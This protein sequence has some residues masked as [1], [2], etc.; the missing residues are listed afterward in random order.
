MYV[1]FNLL[2]I[3][4]MYPYFPNNGPSDTD[5]SNNFNVNS[6]SNIDYESSNNIFSS[7]NKNDNLD[8][9]EK[10][11]L[12]DIS[13]EDFFSITNNTER[14][15]LYDDVT[16]C[17]ETYNQ[18][19]SFNATLGGL[20]D[21]ANNADEMYSYAQDTETPSYDINTN[22]E[23]N[24]PNTTL[25]NLLDDRTYTNEL[26][27]LSAPTDSLNSGKANNSIESLFTDLDTLLSGMHGM[28]DPFP[29]IPQIDAD[30]SCRKKNN[31]MDNLF[32]D[33][34]NLLNGV[35]NVVEQDPFAI[36]IDTNYCDNSYST[37]HSYCDVPSWD[38]IS[39]NEP[40]IDEDCTTSTYTGE[41][42]PSATTDNIPNYDECCVSMENLSSYENKISPSSSAAV[43][44]KHVSNEDDNNSE[45]CSSKKHC[46]L[47]EDSQHVLPKELKLVPNSY[48]R[49]NILAARITK[50]IYEIAAEKID[51]DEEGSFRNSVLTELDDKIEEKNLDESSMDIQRTYSNISRYILDKISPR[52][53]DIIL[54]TD[55]K[56]TAGMSIT[57]IQYRYTSNKVFFDKLQECCK[58]ISTSVN[59]LSHESFL[60][61]I[62]Y[63]VRFCSRNNKNNSHISMRL[64][65]MNIRNRLS[66]SLKYLIVDALRGLPQKIKFIIE[67]FEPT[68]ILQIVFVK[69][70]GVQFAKSSLRKLKNIL[71]N[72]ESVIKNKSEIENKLS[73]ELRKSVV[74]FNEIAYFP[75]ES[76]VKLVTKRLISDI[77][78][79][80]FT[81]NES[82]SL[83][84]K[85][86]GR[87]KDGNPIGVTNVLEYALSVSGQSTLPSTQQLTACEASKEHVPPITAECTIPL[88]S[89]HKMPEELKPLLTAYSTT[90]ICS[91]RL[92][93]SIYEEAIKSI[94]VD[95]K[96]LLR[97]AILKTFSN[98]IEY[99]NF[100][101]SLMDISYTY[102]HIRG[103]VLNKVSLHI[104]NI[105]LT[106][107]III[108]PGMNVVDIKN[109]CISNHEFFDAL[110]ESCKEIATS[111]DKIKDEEF[112]PIIQ[113]RIT[114]GPDNNFIT[115]LKK[116][117]L[118]RK[119]KLSRSSKISVI[120]NVLDLPQKIKNTIEKLEPV[121]I[122]EGTFTLFH[123][124]YASKSLIRN[125]LNIYTN[126]K[127]IAEEQSLAANDSLIKEKLEEE[128][129]KS[130]MRIGEK[131]LSLNAFT[132]KLMAKYLLLDMNKLTPKK[133]SAL[134]I[135]NKLRYLLNEKHP[136]HL[137]ENKEPVEVKEDKQ[138]TNI[139]ELV[140]HHQHGTEKEENSHQNLL[141]GIMP[142]QL[143]L[144]S[145]RY[146]YMD[147]YS[148]K[149]TTSIYERAVK[150]ID[151]DKEKLF[152]NIILEEFKNIIELNGF[153]RQLADVSCTYSK[154]L[155]YILSKVSPIINDI[156]ASNDIYITPEM[157]ISEIKCRCIS[158]KDF[159]DKLQ[160]Y[161]IKISKNINNNT[162]HDNFLTII[163]NHVNF[164]LG[165][166]LW[167]NLKS[168]S[169]AK[170]NKLTMLT[171]RLIV[172]AIYNLP[173]NIISEIEKFTLIDVSHGMFS[174]IHGAYLPKS[175]IRNITKNYTVDK[176]YELA[177]KIKSEKIYYSKVKVELEELMQKYVYKSAQTSVIL[178]GEIT[179]PLSKAL[180]KLI[181]S[182][183]AK[184]IVKSSF[185][186]I[187]EDKQKEPICDTNDS[188]RINIA[189]EKLTDNLESPTANSATVTANN[190]V[191]EE[192]H[193]ENLEH[194]TTSSAII[195]AN[196][197]V[198]EEEPHTE[199]L[200]S[201][202]T[203]MARNKTNWSEHIKHIAPSTTELTSKGYDYDS[204][205][206]SSEFNISIYEYAIKKIDIKN[207]YT[208]VLKEFKWINI[209]STYSNIR[210]YILDIFCHYINNIII[211]ED[212]LVTPGMSIKDV[213][214]AC[215]SN[216]RFFYKLTECCKEVAKTV[217]EIKKEEILSII[218]A[219]KNSELNKIISFTRNRLYEDKKNILYQIMIDIII[220]TINDLPL[221]IKYA[222]SKFETIDIL[223]GV[224]APLHGV[225]INK[226]F[227]RSMVN[228]VNISDY[229]GKSPQTYRHQSINNSTLRAKLEE[230]IEK[231]VV[232]IKGTTFYLN[233][234]LKKSLIRY[235]LLDI[236]NIYHKCSSKLLTYSS[237]LDP[238]SN[239]RSLGLYRFAISVIEF[240]AKNRI[241]GTKYNIY[242]CRDMIRSYILS[243]VNNIINKIEKKI[244]INQWNGMTIEQIRLAYTSNKE[245]FDKLS[246]G[247]S[248][249]V[250]QIKVTG[251]EIVGM[252]I[253]PELRN[254]LQKQETDSITNSI[255]ESLTSSIISLPEKVMDLIGSLPAS[256]IVGEYFSI[257]DN[258]YVDNQTLLKAQSI[259]DSTQKKIEDSLSLYRSAEKNHKNF[260][261]IAI[262]K[263]IVKAQIVELQKELSDPIMTILN[264][265][266]SVANKD[267]RNVILN[268]LKSY[269][270]I[271]SLIKN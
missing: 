50:S 237:S 165:E 51:F 173:D 253:S 223:T 145:T 48:N 255:L 14:S 40:L 187:S 194:P 242:D 19:C 101:K 85:I 208:P 143:E 271:R 250:G 152:K 111:L 65:S 12:G 202:E 172:E 112:L 38:G 144:I 164:G 153:N 188:Q 228:M 215:I 221:S 73:E 80:V 241:F 131:A 252:V 57:D 207:K 94:E 18:E 89:E 147:I 170:R 4:Y 233:E 23:Y 32:T 209:P 117:S 108:T 90:N 36:Q 227:V 225:Y 87:D 53:N 176:I 234:H 3:Q 109:K 260:D 257:F 5:E 134:I 168:L 138:D 161:C 254:I 171:K 245:F 114:F 175:F 148:E 29:F 182:F 52:I 266:V 42:G 20:I 84:N 7:Y 110:Q 247:C 141:V 231:S 218:K 183:L 216:K 100:D 22:R 196:N 35:S 95:E 118:S 243:T 28:V 98:L 265:E 177:I 149:L 63:Y 26:N 97:N 192:P 189:E 60:P 179:Y 102:S 76:T 56:I 146:K 37:E 64:I 246:E 30:S 133:R 211:T 88:L 259:F 59:K 55:V 136:T 113:S 11:L 197:E 159:F 16:N 235:S 99:K 214:D 47:H 158:N 137:T 21:S 123:G 91:S 120:S 244:E 126:Y 33:I 238:N 219:S 251:K 106:K 261:K 71:N 135:E 186:N 181:S 142:E 49:A 15:Y 92:T 203:I 124:G 45:Q 128:C 132:I 190:E 240:N 258:V 212:V 217:N 2:G 54:T 116:I 81:K 222:I 163:Q 69:I 125:A 239:V 119:R 34:D 130:V 232:L 96:K 58:E 72:T 268:K 44:R 160:E 195:T 270:M 122:F 24:S 199:D 156:I 46:Q 157:S 121:N 74:L 213:R 184:D 229:T 78:S 104:N 200:E 267:T 263:K 31:S 166:S 10:Y 262:I 66:I 115:N 67:K 206:P 27:P 86:E 8:S 41:L 224:F 167:T 201:H 180:V 105:I 129:R 248:M 155:K 83:R 193:T 93:M 17:T 204:L 185:D 169:T 68:D 198:A 174:N 62:Q 77:N 13:L 70:H 230:K 107:D 249:I 178:I 1:V 140:N 39:E 79:I 75:N 226:S 269:L 151:F 236:D 256:H 154:M 264:N 25:E 103:Y 139:E 43:K 210:E 205:I 162:K 61:M 127:L 6:C 150:K 9:S 191:A 220:D 82:Q